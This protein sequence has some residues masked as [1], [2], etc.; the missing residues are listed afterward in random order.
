MAGAAL[1]GALLLALFY[2]V[3]RW[4]AGEWLGNDYYSPGPLVPLIS[5][6][7]AWR[8]WS[9]WPADR[10]RDDGDDRLSPGLL[11][12]YVY[13]SCSA[14]FTALGPHRHP[15][16]IIWY[17]HGRPCG[18]WYSCC[19]SAFMAAASEPLSVP[20]C[21]LPARSPPRSCVC[22]VNIEVNGVQ[23]ACPTQ[24]SSA[25][26]SGLRSIVTLLTLVG[27]VVSYRRGVAWQL[28]ARFSSIRL[29]CRM[30]W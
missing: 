17:S 19:L 8:L 26:C 7:F 4:L 15:G 11:A 24:P 14:Y 9:K 23:S 22:S 2:P 13:A 10:R 27:L 28:A 12:V 6:F 3:L 30:F 20:L 1:V 5:A 18:G 21:R 25:Q 29:P 16:G